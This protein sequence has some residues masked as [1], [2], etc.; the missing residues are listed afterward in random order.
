MTNDEFVALAEK[1]K[2]TCPVS[3]L[4]SAA[5]ITLDAALA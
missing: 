5:T 1:A 3:K 2:T 4:Y